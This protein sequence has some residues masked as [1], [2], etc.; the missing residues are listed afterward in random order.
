[1]SRLRAL[2]VPPGA[3]GIGVKAGLCYNDKGS[4]GAL[5]LF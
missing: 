4:D 2:D 1:M 5:G 3:Y